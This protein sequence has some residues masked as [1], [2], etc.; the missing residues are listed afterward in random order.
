MQALRGDLV[1]V[2]L[3]RVPVRARRLAASVL[4]IDDRKSLRQA[5]ASKRRV[6]VHQP[7]G[8][9]ALDDRLQAKGLARRAQGATQHG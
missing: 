4:K 2:V 8:N 3:V 7:D 1:Y 5:A 9:A 6:V